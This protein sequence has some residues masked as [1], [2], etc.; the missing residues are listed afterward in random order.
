MSISFNTFFMIENL[1][2]T[3]IAGG[4]AEGTGPSVGSSLCLQVC[5]L[6]HIFHLIDTK[7]AL[8]FLVFNVCQKNPN[9]K[10]Y[11]LACLKHKHLCRVGPGL[12]LDYKAE[13][14]KGEEVEKQ[15]IELAT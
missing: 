13:R 11:K 1:E 15:L 14:A 2:T 8:D 9:I 4:A 12:D 6:S 10:I 7:G 5:P 3:K